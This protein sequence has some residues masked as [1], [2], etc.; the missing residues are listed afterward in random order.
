M[1]IIAI[2]TLS[3][4]RNQNISYSLCWEDA[5][6]VLGALDTKP[7][8]RV[9]SITSGGCNTL[10]LASIAKE[11]VYAVDSNPA[12]NYL[13]IL[14]HVASK[15]LNYWQYLDFLGVSPCP[16][17]VQTL[18]N[19]SPYLPSECAEFFG[20]H[21]DWVARGIIHCGVFEGYMKIFRRVVL[22]LV[23]SRKTVESILS[24]TDK[25]E[26]LR[27]YTEH[28]DN[29]NYRLFGRIFFSQF[30]MQALGRHRNMFRYTNASNKGRIYLER[31]GGTLAK[32]VVFQNPYLE[33]ILCG[34]FN[35]SL[36]LFLNQTNF[37]SYRQNSNIEFVSSGI[38]QF[39]SGLPDASIHKFNLSDV[40]EG[41]SEADCKGVMGQVHRTATNGARIIFWNNLVKRDVQEELRP[42]FRLEDAL[43]NKYKPM[44]KVFFYDSFYIYTIQK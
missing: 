22:P 39:L 23:Q 2:Q 36:P 42:Y 40:F 14:K 16:H 38:G 7:H 9:V 25:D 15:H 34:T 35:R 21:T 17:R 5:D 41:M 33:Y 28:W 11:K 8:D 19:L 18:L 10:A 12:Q 43:I 26:Q 30:V 24:V 3:I 37:D 20:R 13:A 27:I 6:L 4:Y 1:G 32:G 44:E 31:A 29:P